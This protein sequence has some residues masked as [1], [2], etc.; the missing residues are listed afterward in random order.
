MLADGT[1]SQQFHQ[2]MHLKTSPQVQTF[3][4]YCH[5][6]ESSSMAA[7][8]QNVSMSQIQT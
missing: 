2:T 8:Q 1:P 3:N 7:D 5:P 4:D 6:D